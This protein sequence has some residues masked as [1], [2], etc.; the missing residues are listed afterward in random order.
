MVKETSC[1]PDVEYLC[2][3]LRPFYLPREFGSILLCVLYIPPNG[4]VSRAAICISDCIQNQ[5]QRTPG[6]PVLI[7]G[8]F[9]QCK[10]ESFL[11]GFFQHVKSATR[12]NNVLDKCY[13]N[14][15]E[16]FKAKIKPPLSTSDHNIVHL[17]PT[18]KTALKR[19]KPLVKTVTVWDEGNV[20]ALKGCFFK[21]R[22]VSISRCRLEYNDG[23]D[24]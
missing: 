21:Y 14:I 22:L 6:A 11:P 17:I 4:N 23:D 12:N 18:Y 16:A 3:S 7:M 13:S 1:N 15:R 8:D 9:N 24:H 10:F 19:N 5:L 20:E 2:L